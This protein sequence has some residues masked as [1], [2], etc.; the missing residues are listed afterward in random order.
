MSFCKTHAAQNVK[1]ILE[2][3]FAISPNCTDI[4]ANYCLIQIEN[5]K[6]CFLALDANSVTV[7]KLLTRPAIC[8]CDIHVN[9]QMYMNARFRLSISSQVH[10]IYK[11][12]TRSDVY[13]C[14]SI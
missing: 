11:T 10:F 1:G 3:S 6:V 13:S 12:F 8:N 14:C 7:D 9:W 5:V 4:T 2:V